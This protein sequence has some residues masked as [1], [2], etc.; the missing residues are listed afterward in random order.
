MNSDIEIHT[1]PIVLCVKSKN[2][3]ELLDSGN[4]YKLER[5]GK[6]KIKRP[7]P[8]ALWTKF[9]D[10]EAWN[11]DVSFVVD[12][13]NSKWVFKKDVPKKW[14]ISFD[15][16]SFGIKFGSFKHVGVFPEQTPN[17]QWII[18][19]IKSKNETDDEA[20]EKK[21]PEVLN[22][23]GYTGGSTLAASL[24]GASVVHLDGSKVAISSAKE[25]A[26]L[27]GLSKNPIRWILDDARD[28]VKKEINRGRRYDG[29]I[30]DP[31]AFGRGPDGQIWKIEDDLVP[32]INDCFKILSDKPIFFLINGYASGYSSTTYLNNLFYLKDKFGGNLE[33]G[34]LAIEESSGKRLLPC[35][36]FA[37]W[38]F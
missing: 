11:A 33:H 12:S 31:P 2:D 14:N 4:G 15:D 35:G 19:T 20:I 21:V 36:I 17:W 27:S 18:E 34:E 38:K 8:Q 13:E 24:A 29:I 37:R 30:M 10:D 9:L 7:D 5:F 25:N 32:L 28:F 6:F 26:E 16:L 23:F 22:L 3:Y 1:Q